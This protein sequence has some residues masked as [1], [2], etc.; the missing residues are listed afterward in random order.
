MMEEQV[1]LNTLHRDLRDFKNDM[2]R[3]FE[4]VNNRLNN[5]EYQI[6]NAQ[7][8]TTKWGVGLSVGTIVIVTGL[9]ASYAASLGVS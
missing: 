3:K 5:L 9:V 7:S 8:T 6:R 2:D 1:S 4:G